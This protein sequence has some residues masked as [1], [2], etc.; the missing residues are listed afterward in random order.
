MLSGLLTCGEC[1][2]NYIMVNKKEYG[3]STYR[4]RGK[5]ACK[6]D[7]RVRRELI[8]GRVFSSFKDYLFTP[9]H[10]TTFRKE[11]KRALTE[12]L[13]Q[14]LALNSGDEDKIKRIDKEIENLM[15]A[16]K[17]GIVTSTVQAELKALEAEKVKYEQRVRVEVQEIDQIHSVIPEIEQSF[18]DILNCRKPLP[19]GNVA[20][21][22][23]RIQMILGKN[24]KVLPRQDGKGLMAEIESQYKGLM[25]LSGLSDDKLNLVA[26]ARFEL[27]T[28][29]L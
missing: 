22:R 5:A 17:M 6:N 20:K 14:K 15:T 16:L 8:E 12:A 10:L 3:C 24:I 2:A 26:G 28:F 29:R 9:E 1:G 21:L 11:V 27:T 18:I 13:Q 7:L 25:K 4:N 23:S 19:V